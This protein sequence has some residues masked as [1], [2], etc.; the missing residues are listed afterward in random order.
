MSAIAEAKSVFLSFVQNSAD[1]IKARNARAAI[2]NL[3]HGVIERKVDAVEMCEM[4]VKDEKL[5]ESEAL[6][7]VHYYDIC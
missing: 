3:M 4:L 5:H 1:I 6:K 2:L 7:E